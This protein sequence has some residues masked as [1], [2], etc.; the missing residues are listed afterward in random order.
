MNWSATLTFEGSA[1]IN[2]PSYAPRK[3]TSHSNARAKLAQQPENAGYHCRPTPRGHHQSVLRSNTTETI[4][5]DVRLVGC[6]RARARMSLE[7]HKSGQCSRLCC[8]EL[9][10]TRSAAAAD[11]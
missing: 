4:A 3:V 1:L 9:Q 5:R 11:V 10:G 2:L 7:C 8:G 6:G